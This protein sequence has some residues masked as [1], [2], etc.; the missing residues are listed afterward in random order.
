MKMITEELK[1]ARLTRHGDLKDGSIS[2]LAHL[3][4]QLLRSKEPQDP[5]HPFFMISRIQKH[6]VKSATLIKFEENIWIVREGFFNVHLFI[7]GLRIYSI[8]HV[9]DQVQLVSCHVLSL[10]LYRSLSLTPSVC[11]SLTHPLS[12]A[13]C[14][15]LTHCISFSLPVFLFL[16]FSHCPLYLKKKTGAEEKKERKTKLNGDDRSRDFKGK[17]FVE[18]N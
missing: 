1:V 8:I 10:F 11:R 4:G 17:N 18:I 3:K 5:P 13:P 7:D 14:I 12:L 16:P 2:F 6:H 15:S 9:P